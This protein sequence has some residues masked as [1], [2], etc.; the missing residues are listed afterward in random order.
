MVHQIPDEEGGYLQILFYAICCLKLLTMRYFLGKE[1]ETRVVRECGFL[2]TTMNTCKNIGM[3][4]DAGQIMCSCDA[5][6]CNSSSQLKP[7][8]TFISLV[9]L[10]AVS[11]F[12]KLLL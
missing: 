9:M 12:L 3:H 6:K 5:E 1:I 2:N 10:I 11:A 4:K 8:K 7:Q